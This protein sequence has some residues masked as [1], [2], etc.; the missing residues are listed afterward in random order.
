MTKENKI[1]VGVFIIL[2]V[3]VL[4]F[5]PSSLSVRLVKQIMLEWAVIAFVALFFIKPFWMKLFLLWSLTLTI[6]NYTQSK[7]IAKASYFT[8]MTVFFSFIVFQVIYCKIKDRKVIYKILDFFCIVTIIQLTMM[9]LQM[10]GVWLF[11]TPKLELTHSSYIVGFLDNT[12]TSGIFLALML[13]AFFRKNWYYII[14]FIIV[15]LVKTHCFAAILSLVAGVSFY[16]WFILKSYRISIFSILIL[17]AVIYFLKYEG[18]EKLLTFNKRIPLWKAVFNE[19]IPIHWVHGWGP[20][21]FRVIV[22]KAKKAYVHNEYLQLWLEYGVIGVGIVLGYI[23]SLFTKIYK[24]KT[25]LSTILFTA[26]LIGLI[27]AFVNFYM[28]LTAGIIM[29]IYFVLFEKE[30]EYAKT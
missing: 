6:W 28:H 7:E 11:F 10:F 4:G 23:T 15:A 26:I 24:H 3:G 27:N 22:S 29:I 8:T 16:L 12:N 18:F 25:Y 30:T 17:L 20:G 19:L 2:I 21:Q 1:E 13:P 5:Y 14:P 9:Y